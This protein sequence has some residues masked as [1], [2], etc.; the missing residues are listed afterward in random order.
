MY[1]IKV[2]LGADIFVI[3]SGLAWLLL[4]PNFN[5]SAFNR[6]LPS[7]FLGVIVLLFGIYKGFQLRRAYMRLKSQ[8]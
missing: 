6:P 3:F 2:L 7:T 5:L 4:V 8:I 1:M